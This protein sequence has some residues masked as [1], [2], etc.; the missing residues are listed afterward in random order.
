MSE[1]QTFCIKMTA[2]QILNA[3]SGV[4]SALRSEWFKLFMHIMKGKTILVYQPKFVMLLSTL[5]C[6]VYD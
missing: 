4:Q 3:W 2:G 6:V 1:M 5:R